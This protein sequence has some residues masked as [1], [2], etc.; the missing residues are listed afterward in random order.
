MEP[1]SPHLSLAPLHANDLPD[2][3]P[4][5]LYFRRFYEELFKPVWESAFRREKGHLIIGQPGIGN[6][7]VLFPH[8]RGL[9]PAR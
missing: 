8:T 6:Y 7:H 9:L 5:T 1:D 3:L 4:I 2:N